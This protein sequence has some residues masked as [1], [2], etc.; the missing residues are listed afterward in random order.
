MRSDHRQKLVKESWDSMSAA[1]RYNRAT[2][3]VWRGKGGVTHRWILGCGDCDSVFFFR[4]FPAVYCLSINRGMGYVS[5]STYNE[6]EQA[7]GQ[8]YVWSQNYLEDFAAD[9][10][11]GRVPFEDLTPVNQAKYLVNRWY[12]SLC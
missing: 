5:L 3:A 1:G 11:R 12:D 6:D 4:D 10:P 9:F 7:A 8:G 2:V